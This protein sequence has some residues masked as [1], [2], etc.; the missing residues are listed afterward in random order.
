MPL[1][2]S[3]IISVPVLGYLCVSDFRRHVLPN[4]WTLGMLAVVLTWRIG[5]GG[6][7][8]FL[9]GIYGGLLGGAFMLVPF[10]LGAAGGGDVKLLLACGA[11]VGLANVPALLLCTSFCGLLLALALLFAK[12]VSAARL[13]HY[14]LCLFWWGYDRESGRKELPPIHSEKNMVPFGIA[15]SAGTWLTLLYNAIASGGRLW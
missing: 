1:L 9:D 10:L 13:K 7:S 4:A 5:Y 6:L 2:V 14:F 8:A 3:I 12:V 11:L 15:I